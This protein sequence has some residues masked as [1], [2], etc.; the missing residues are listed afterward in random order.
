MSKDLS[1]QMDVFGVLNKVGGKTMSEVVHV[2]TGM[3]QIITQ[4][5]KT[6]VARN[7]H[8]RTRLFG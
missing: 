7:Q 2:Q 4:P 6:K 5:L 3:P 1:N 8:R